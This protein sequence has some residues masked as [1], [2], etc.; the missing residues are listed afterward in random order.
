MAQLNDYIAENGTNLG[1]PTRPINNRDPN[2][3]ARITPKNERGTV[4]LAYATWLANYK[5]NGFTIPFDYTGL[6][7]LDERPVSDLAIRYE[8]YNAPSGSN[9]TD[10]SGNSRTGVLVGATHNAGGDFFSFDGVNDY[11]R[12]PDLYGTGVSNPDTFSVSVWVYPT[13]AGV[14]LSITNT[15]TPDTAYHFSAIEFVD[16]VGKPVPYFGIWNSGIQQDTG[17]ALN[18][19]QWY[20]LAQTYN[21]TTMKGYVNG[22]EVASV[23]S[24]YDSPLDDPTVTNHYFLFGAEDPTDMGDGSYYN[25]RMDQISIYNDALTPSEVNAYYTNTKSKYGL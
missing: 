7:Y 6:N 2:G 1:V 3:I 9:I 11:I 13:A 22:V 10:V 5:A 12:T 18:Y 19:N 15:T 23:T 24:A 14:V 4:K 16:S 21:G 20:H 25:G 17:S 8:A